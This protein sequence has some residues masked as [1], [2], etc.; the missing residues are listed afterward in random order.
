MQ[1][2]AETGVALAPPDQCPMEHRTA[3]R[4]RKARVVERPQREWIPTA[5]IPPR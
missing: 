4:H 5:T 1:E 2:R 3:E